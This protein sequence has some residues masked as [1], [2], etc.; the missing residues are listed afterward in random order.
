[1]TFRER[2]VYKQHM[3]H[4]AHIARPVVAVVGTL[5]VLAALTASQGTMAA[6]AR[7]PAV[8]PVDSAHPAGGQSERA[9]PPATS[10]AGC[11]VFP[12]NNYWN[13]TVTQLP[14]SPFSSVWMAHMTPDSNLHPDFGKSYGEQPVPYGI[15]LT[16]VDDTHPTV[17]VDFTYKKQSDNV[18]YP[19]GAD[20]RIEG[21]RQSSGDKHA[22]VLNTSTCRLYETWNTTEVGGT[23]YAGSGATWDLN[24]NRL[25]PVGWTSADA[26]GLPI[27]PGLLRYDEVEVTG[28]VTHAIRFTTDLTQTTHIW[29]AR[30]DAG[31][32][33]T[34]D[35]PPMG[36]RFRLKAGF[37]TDGYRADTVVVLEA[38]KTYGLVLADNGSPWFFQGSMDRRW[39][40]GLLDELK[41]IPANA[42]EAVNTH[43]MKVHRNSG[44]AR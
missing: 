21:G 28:Q 10:I 44:E 12:D 17:D 23:W 9:V 16:L 38:M 43:Q 37:P 39:P 22:L 35:Y 31:S 30:H 32:Q 25:R 15:P 27:L 24:S 29:P 13:A 11:P 5:T 40:A 34:P 42:F 8:G 14:V 18:P 6:S 33:S 3:A 26:A 7:A 19:L 2:Q 1:L 20:T 36:A 4:T 41:T